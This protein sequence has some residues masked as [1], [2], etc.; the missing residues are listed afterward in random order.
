MEAVGIA[1]V[2]GNQAK[3]R[4]YERCILLRGKFDTEDWWR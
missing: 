1:K 2:K 3:A 4:M